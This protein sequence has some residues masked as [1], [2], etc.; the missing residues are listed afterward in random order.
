VVKVVVTLNHAN[1][2]RLLKLPGG[3]VYDT[4]VS[5]TLEKTAVIAT[6]T[7]PVETGFLR[8]NR[9]IDIHA[10]AGSLRG[11][12][13]YNAPYALYV[14]KGTGIYGPRGAPITP[15]RGKYLVF[16]GRDGGLVYAR[17][18]KGQHA[19]PFLQDAFRAACPWPVTIH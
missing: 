5:G 14:L 9:S 2:D 17:S 16:R 4:V 13:A 12:L 19:Q 3:P 6:V 8:N 15:K 11:T 1:L 10:S 7:A 18:V